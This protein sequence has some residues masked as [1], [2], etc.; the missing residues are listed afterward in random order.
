MRGEAIGPVKARGPNLGEC[1]NREATVC[2]FEQEDGGWDR[3]VLTGE[4]R[5]VANN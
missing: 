2:R 3:D 1:L 4:M 5:K